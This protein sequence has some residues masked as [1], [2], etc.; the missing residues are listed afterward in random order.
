M[1]D[2]TKTDSLKVFK[3]YAVSLP[4]KNQSLQRIHFCIFISK[5]GGRLSPVL[6]EVRLDGYTLSEGQEAITA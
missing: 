1:T 3:W 2:T 5:P 6:L 4:Y